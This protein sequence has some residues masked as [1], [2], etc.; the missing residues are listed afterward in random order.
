ML[1]KKIWVLAE[2]EGFFHKE[3]ER[4]I[5]SVAAESTTTKKNFNQLCNSCLAQISVPIVRIQYVGGFSLKFY[6]EKHNNDKLCKPCFVRMS[7]PSIKIQQMPGFGL[8]TYDTS[9]E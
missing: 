5:T 1:L 9:T 7:V 8:K 2:E 3:R 4:R 6:N